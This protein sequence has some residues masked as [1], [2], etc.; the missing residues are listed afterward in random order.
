MQPYPNHHDLKIGFYDTFTRR[1]GNDQRQ[2]LR[3]ILPY[4]RGD[5]AETPSNQL[6]FFLSGEG[7]TGKS[8]LVR[9]LREAAKVV[10]GMDGPLEPMISI[11][12]TGS[13]AFAIGGYTWHNMLGGP[14]PTKAR[15]LK[16]N[17]AQTLARKLA[18]T[19]VI[20]I[21]EVSMLGCRH[22]MD[23]CLILQ[24]VRSSMVA[25]TDSDRERRHKLQQLPFGGFHMLFTGDFYQFPPVMQK[26]LYAS[27]TNLT[28]RDAEGRRTWLHCVTQFHELKENFRA[29]RSADGST[30]VLAQFLQGARIG[31][32]DAALL[33]TINEQCRQYGDGTDRIDP[34]ALWM[35]PTRAEVEEYNEAA[36]QRLQDDGRPRYRAIAGHIPKELNT[37]RRLAPADMRKAAEALFKYTHDSGRA[38]DMCGELPSGGKCMSVRRRILMCA[39]THHSLSVQIFRTSSD[40]A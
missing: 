11:T 35:A 16:D 28:D 33:R 9:I 24:Q 32:P 22:L 4:L 10:Y 38:N 12:P 39:L 13:S 37:S 6:M 36:F 18:G 5:V 31:E 7:G 20:N 29:L 27:L 2:A 14:L 26:P 40:S 21:D 15:R 25:V 19:K 1:C 23:I 8:E 3:R 17:Q 30:P 34:R